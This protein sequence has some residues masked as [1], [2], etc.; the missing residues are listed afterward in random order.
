MNYLFDIVR[1]RNVQN[2]VS[3]AIRLVIKTRRLRWTPLR[4]RLVGSP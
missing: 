3:I 1:L 2:N 4:T